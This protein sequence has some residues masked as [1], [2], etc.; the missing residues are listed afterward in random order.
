MSITF[1][2]YGLAPSDELDMS[3]EE[4]AAV[5]ELEFQR[6]IVGSASL[7]AERKNRVTG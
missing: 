7:A 6:Q 3:A 5:T 4:Q 2:R 1:Y